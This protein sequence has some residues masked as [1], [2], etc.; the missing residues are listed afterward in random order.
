MAS[1]ALVRELG[2]M[3]RSLAGTSLSPSAVHAIIEIGA[4]R[5]TT[6]RELVAALQLEKSTVSRL[7]R[8]LGDADLV[9]ER[10]DDRD[11]R[12]KRLALT[13]HGK[14]ALAHVTRHA[15]QQVHSAISTLP[16]ADVAGIVDG[17]ET[18]A[19]AL[20][21]SRGSAAA[22]DAPRFRLGSG[23]R[24]TLLA[25]VVEMHARYYSELVAFGLPFEA[26]VAADMADF[27]TRADR[28]RNAIW[29]VEQGGVVSGSIAIDGEDLGADIAHLRWF[30]VD[31]ALLGTG[32]GKALLREALAFCD[33]AGFAE[34]HLWTFAGLD[35]ARSLYERT[36]FALVAEWRGGQW[37]AT[38]M[39]Q[40]FVRP[41]GGQGAGGQ[42]G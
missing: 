30:I 17:L 24:P 3:G 42:R 9:R 15:E 27:L 33:R 22:E 12:I 1:R 36:G 13:P 8:S 39:E 25:R 7:L 11:V 41:G 29:H 10:T 20:A 38:V 4:G 35:R 19:S 5:C 23:Y 16:A 31:D 26:R 34:T 6:A 14:R 21:A 28:P 37:G 18:Y 2:F 40:K 32:A